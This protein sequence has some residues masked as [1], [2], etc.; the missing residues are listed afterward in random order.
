[1]SAEA[2]VGVISPV[3]VIDLRHEYPG[4]LAHPHLNSYVRASAGSLV[5]ADQVTDGIDM[6]CVILVDEA[7][8]LAEHSAAF[9]F[10]LGSAVVR[11]VICVSLGMADPAERTAVVLPSVL[12]SESVTVLWAGDPVGIPWL[13]GHGAA[14]VVQTTPRPGGG[15]PPALLDLLDALRTRDVFLRVSAEAQRVDTPVTAPAVR[16]VSG[17]LDDT[18]LVAAE[19]RALL[20]VVAGGEVG[21]PG[22]G[23][24]PTPDAAGDVRAVEQAFPARPGVRP[25]GRVRT[26][27]EA[28]EAAVNGIDATLAAAGRWWAVFTPWAGGNVSR[29]SAAG[30][31]A[32]EAYR[33]ELAE[34]FRALDT[35]RDDQRRAELRTRGVTLPPAPPFRSTVVD[36]L[37]RLVQNSLDGGHGLEQTVKLLRGV[38]AK[39]LPMGS[40][41]R[42]PALGEAVA[43][44]A[45]PPR[46]AGGFGSP[47]VPLLTV[48]APA[49]AAAAPR[50]FW[51]AGL[52]AVLVL[53]L[54]AVAVRVKRRRLAL[55]RPET[56]RDVAAVLTVALLAAGGAALPTAFPFSAAAQWGPASA[57]TGLVLAVL[58]P[59]LWGR[60]LVR[61]W[62]REIA[63]GTLRPAVDRLN[64]LWDDATGEWVVADARRRASNIVRSAAA[65]LDKI[66]ARFVARAGALAP[67]PGR[68]PRPR[69]GGIAA[70]DAMRHD[71][72]ALVDLGLAD[73]WP[74]AR[75]GELDGLAER[76]EARAAE[77]LGEYE[78]HLRS[79]GVEEPPPAWPSRP[80]IVE[81][82][83][84]DTRTRGVVFA[85]GEPVQLLCSDDQ[86]SLLSRDLRRA[87]TVRFAPRLARSAFA[88]PDGL[89]PADE[90]AGVLVWTSSGTAAGL[91]HL[92]PL[93]SGV[94]Y[95]Q[96]ESA[97]PA[98]RFR[99]SGG[100]PR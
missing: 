72:V 14:S 33:A 15:D 90:S 83:W 78:E 59:A 9:A 86:V 51:Y 34:L 99:P 96:T 42:V 7:A 80:D 85:V 45:A 41:A 61:R 17:R 68:A 49:V 47:I 27:R 57:V 5:P 91:L 37:R 30:A 54:G 84:S 55:D 63:G 10:V 56:S 19:R 65:G 67:A 97:A 76:A 58:T 53:V 25:G 52:A 93:R 21:E 40:A 39:L 26:R 24:V 64:R 60:L 28:A 2:T 13:I 77:L 89:D 79:R 8:R 74:E 31:G 95:V 18:V 29:M 70:A 69:S 36:D 44:I 75:A 32:V 43:G 62:V 3:P 1:M 94:R 73:R 12:N 98:E 20:A 88:G 4:L 22:S 35:G 50:P 48:V 100:A 81:P 66:R 92:V 16:I 38:S 23:R 6:S 46:M 82:P 11:K 87:A 71:L